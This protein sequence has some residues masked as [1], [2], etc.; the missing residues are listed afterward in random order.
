M[1]RITSKTEGKR[2]E[3]K[4]KERKKHNALNRERKMYYEMQN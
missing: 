3:K 4:E 2:S 1:Q